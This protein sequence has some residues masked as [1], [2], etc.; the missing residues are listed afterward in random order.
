MEG[1]LVDHFWAWLH[2]TNPAKMS[3]G[4]YQAGF[5]MIFWG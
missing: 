2:L 3:Q 4:K 5:W 1:F